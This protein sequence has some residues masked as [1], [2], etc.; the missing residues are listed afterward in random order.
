M[1][2]SPVYSAVIAL[3][4]VLSACG[5]ESDAA[6]PSA[7]QV[8]IATLD[9]GNYPT[10]PVDVEATRHPMAGAVRES[11]KIGAASPTPYEYD[12]RFVY[13]KNGGQP[14]TETNP[15]YYGGSGFDNAKTTLAA[16]PG[17]VAGWST[18][19][20]RREDYQAGRSIETKVV[21]Y[22]TSE[23]A[24]FAYDEL[25]I[26]T[27]GEPGQ[28]PGHPDAQVKVLVN[29]GSYTT[30]NMRAWI[31]K[32]DLLIHADLS[33]PVSVHFDA[34]A[35]SD[36]IKRFFDK[37]LEMLESYT[38]TPVAEIAKQPI[39]VDGLLSRTLPA[40]A[41]KAAGAGVYPAQ[42][43]LHTALRLD[44]LGPAL[45]DAEIDYASINLAVVYR[46]RDSAAAVRYMA[47]EEV[48]TLA[49]SRHVKAD[50]PPTMPGAQC[51]DLAP[52]VATYLAKPFCLGTVGRYVIKSQASNLQ[53]AYQQLGAQ[54]KLLADN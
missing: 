37:Q 8:D 46:A 28:I 19:A 10:T 36:I 18:N 26:R 31:R 42:A 3:T 41:D 32:G 50:G 4:L 29:K 33:D 11:I 34:A 15:A 44:T 23:Q 38:P 54:Y 49:D 2:K 20:K 5:D 17:I 14:V 43:L 9:S 40:E 53:D 27:Q 7:P 35:N 21:R 51:Y 47:A 16:I 39:D 6:T 52:K 22:S 30:Q 12:H 25:V 1:R 45:R 48:D 13:A 24:R